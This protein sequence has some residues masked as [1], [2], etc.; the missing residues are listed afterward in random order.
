[1]KIMISRFARSTVLVIASVSVA[2][3]CTSACKK[4]SEEEKREVGQAETHSAEVTQKAQAQAIDEK[5]QW[6]AAVRREQLELKAH[7]QDDIDKIDKRLMDLKVE[8]KKD[9]TGYDYDPKSPEAK[10]VTTLLEKRQVLATDMTTIERSDERGWDETKAN[11]ER[12]L[13]ASTGSYRR[14]F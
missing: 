14:G 7:V 6:L 4:S 1:M 11:I 8:L 10:E 13:S 5:N 9:G 12:H 3:F 2:A